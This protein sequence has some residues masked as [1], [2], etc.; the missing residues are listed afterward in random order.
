MPTYNYDSSLLTKYLRDR[1]LFAWN[2][3]NRNLVQAGQ[4][5]RPEQH[6]PVS[7]EVTLNRV[8]GGV[9]PYRNGQ[10]AFP[11]D[12]PPV[13]EGGVT[14]TP[15]PPPPVVPGGVAQWVTG[16]DGIS[17]VIIE[18]I[19]TDSLNNTYVAG[20]F[21]IFEGQTINI[22]SQAGLTGTTINVTNFATLGG[23]GSFPVF[24]N[25]IAKYNSD[26]IAQ[27]V[28]RLDGNLFQKPVQLAVD[29][30]DSIYLVGYCYTSVSLYSA[31]DLVTPYGLLTLSQNPGNILVKYNSSGIIQWATYVGEI[32]DKA[33]AVATDSDNNV[34]ISSRYTGN[35]LNIY[36]ANG[37]S[38]GNIQTTL[39][40]TL[41][42]PPFGDFFYLVKYNTFGTAQWATRMTS[43]SMNNI[44]IKVNSN[45][46]VYLCGNFNS[47]LNL[48]NPGQS[49]SLWGELN[50]V[51]GSPDCFLAKFSASTGVP[52]WATNMGS[53]NYD[54]DP[55]ID[56][57]STGN[58]VIIGNFEAP[59]TAYNYSS[60]GG[61]GAPLVLVA[62]SVTLTPIGSYDTFIIK[63]TPAGSAIWGTQMGGTS[64][65]F[66]NGLILGSDDSIYLTCLFT[67]NPLNIYS[68]TGTPSPITLT[69][70]SG[71]NSLALVKYS[72][73]GT[74]Q[75]AT[76]IGGASGINENYIKVGLA[77]SNNFVYVANSYY[78][79]GNPMEPV[80]M[81]SYTSTD[82][83]TGAVSLTLYGNLANISQGT[84]NNN[85]NS[86]LAKY[87]A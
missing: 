45:T 51:G 36:N 62:S 30:A 43:S 83:G 60:G 72:S 80:S 29:S 52:I 87:S 15:P 44:N 73:T 50:G 67:S 12:L 68:T 6:P 53:I 59:L 28:T 13:A 41:D 40:G 82:A 10:E 61:T 57:D 2:F 46:D 31:N 27:W 70:Y 75:W 54:I 48:Y 39:F 26:G 1:N 47:F 85:T 32:S 8:V 14:P 34:Y 21:R 25:F 3:Y 76:I 23:G 66:N 56:I 7:E 20:K 78:N 55:S 58:I 49:G 42:S 81:Y 38:G 69:P 4:S 37:V 79:P 74:A 33:C 9:V 11:F 77:F 63:Y 64:S 17:N 84:F 86:F 5:V 65:E 16:I 18:S 19:V 22:N 35:P 71:L 24:N